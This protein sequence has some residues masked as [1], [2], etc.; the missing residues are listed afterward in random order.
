MMLSTADKVQLRKAIR[1]AVKTAIYDFMRSHPNSGLYIYSGT[2]TS[3]R[4]AIADGSYQYE[5]CY[6]VPVRKLGKR[7]VF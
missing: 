7:R 6:D 4:Y 1:V 3:V 2:V 5:E